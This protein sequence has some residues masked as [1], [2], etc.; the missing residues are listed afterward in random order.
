MEYEIIPQTLPG[1]PTLVVRGHIT[2]PMVNRWLPRA[3]NDVFSHLRRIGAQPAGPPFVRYAFHEGSFDIEAG[4]PVPPGCAGQ[5]AVEASTLPAGPVVR[6][7][8]AGPY[9]GLDDAVHAL[10][11]WLDDRGWIPKGPH[12]ESYLTKPDEAGEPTKWRTE[13]VQP[14][15]PADPTLN[16]SAQ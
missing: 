11:D 8:H 2:R 4:V 12:W 10:L 15:R 7:L 1:Q 14:Y 16:G 9:Q 5:G 13:V 3:F 6:T